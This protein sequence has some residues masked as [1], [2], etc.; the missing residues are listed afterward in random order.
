M[1]RRQHAAILGTFVYTCISKPPFTTPHLRFI[2]LFSHLFS[3]SIQGFRRTHVMHFKCPSFF[4]FKRHKRTEKNFSAQEPKCAS[5][6]DSFSLQ[7][8]CNDIE[9]RSSTQSLA[10]HKSAVHANREVA[11][12][13]ISPPN[14]LSETGPIVRNL[15]NEA[16]EDLDLHVQLELRK[17]GMKPK[18]DEPMSA[19]IQA[20]QKEAEKQRNRSLAREWKLHIG[21][22][23]IPIRQL[24][25]DISWWA[26]KIGAVAVQ[27]APS[28]GG[29]VWAVLVSILQVRSFHKEKERRGDLTRQENRE[30][31]LSTKKKL[32]C[33]LLSARWP[34]PS[35]AARSISKY[36]PSR[37]PRGRRLWRSSRTL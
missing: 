33:F 2:S 29:G 19:Q 30:L 25:I 9:A 20:F 22:R 5:C 4:T 14:E 26:K 11:R 17:Q 32:P 27:F 18:S 21:N 34:Q 3:N 6:S 7:T 36:I 31:I 13:E 28:P 37:E 23:E 35:I 12:D 15:W 24:T 1:R 8:H 16:F 10:V